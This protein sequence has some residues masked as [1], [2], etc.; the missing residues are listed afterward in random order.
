MAALEAPVVPG[1]VLVVVPPIFLAI[2]A[3]SGQINP[4][5]YRPLMAM[6]RLPTLP[7]LMFP[8]VT[9]KDPAETLVTIPI[10]SP[11]PVQSPTPLSC[12]SYTQA[13]PIL[14]VWASFS[15]QIPSFLATMV[16]FSTPHSVPVY[17]AIPAR[18]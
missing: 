7:P 9:T 18:I 17:F 14:G 8:S 6:V 16:Y 2:A 15:T 12:Q 11:A 4:R 13:S 10:W 1:V 5:I 3:K